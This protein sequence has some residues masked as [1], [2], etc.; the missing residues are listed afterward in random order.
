MTNGQNTTASANTQKPAADDAASTRSSTSFASTISL[1]KDSFKKGKGDKDDKDDKKG[2]S[3]KKP[4]SE[5]Y[6]STIVNQC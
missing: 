5:R 6:T 2:S 1:V 3:S 4:A